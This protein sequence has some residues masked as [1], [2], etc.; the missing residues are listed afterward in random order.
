MQFIEA[1]KEKEK[2]LFPLL[3]REQLSSSVMLTTLE[4]K[5]MRVTND[6]S[7]TLSELELR[8]REAENL[9]LSGTMFYL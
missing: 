7:T 5:L 4:E 9:K 2:Q 1:P 6:I 3:P 8:R